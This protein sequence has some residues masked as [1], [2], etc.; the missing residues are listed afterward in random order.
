MKKITKITGIKLFAIALLLGASQLLT[1]QDTIINVPLGLVDGHGALFDAIMGDVDDNGDRLHPNATYRLTRGQ[2]YPV[3][4]MHFNFNITIDAADGEGKPPM[5]VPEK[6]LSGD[7]PYA[8]FFQ[9]DSNAVTLKNLMFSAISFDKSIIDYGISIKSGK[10]V[11]ENCIFHGFDQGAIGGQGAKHYNLHVNNTIFRNN[12]GV[13]RWWEGAPIMLWAG[14]GDTLSITNSTF[15][16]NTTVVVSNWE[17]HYTKYYKFS[18]NTVYGT[19]GV[20]QSSFAQTNSEITD[21]MFINIFA[22]GIDTTGYEHGEGALPGDQT[23]IVPVGENDVEKMKEQI[24][25][26]SEADRKMIVRNNVYFWSQEVKDYW[27]SRGEQFPPASLNPVFMNPETMAMFDD[28]VAYPLFDES[29]NI[30]ADPG[31]VDSEME[32]K[33]IAGFLERGDILYDSAANG[34]SFPYVRDPFVHF[35]P[36]ESGIANIDFYIEWPL[37]EDLTYTNEV[38]MTASST[39]GPVGDPRWYGID[40]IDDGH[41]SSDL[42][43][44]ISNYPNPFSYAT[45]IRYKIEKASDVSIEMF[46]AVGQK[47]AVLVNGKK[48]AG[49]HNIQWKP[50][51]SRGIYFCKMQ[52][53]SQSTYTKVVYHSR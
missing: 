13:K 7:L 35:Y 52:V 27:A 12:Q 30:E 29:D 11:V 8:M 49:T 38:L 15:F 48:Q 53:G 4:E 1:A 33:V 5:I 40:G 20:G 17:Q 28:E 10:V 32:A 24:G 25:V 14:L 26:E 3:P 37:T 46:N 41:F 36:F 9:M 22:F 51:V 16:N 42:L 31:F 44:Q 39:G 50:T 2:I 45:T 6:D 23:C 19:G 34:S 21:N 43:I 47:V 18:H